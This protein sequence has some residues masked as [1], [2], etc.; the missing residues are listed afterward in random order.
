MPLIL[1]RFPALSSA[2][3]GNCN[4]VLLASVGPPP[5]YLENPPDKGDIP[6]IRYDA[7]SKEL[8]RNG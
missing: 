8:I 4:K 6:A 1:P 5:D 2:M 7:G 3:P